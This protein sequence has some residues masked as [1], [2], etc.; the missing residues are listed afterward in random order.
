MKDPV[1]ERSWGIYYL[2]L[3]LT[4]ETKKVPKMDDRGR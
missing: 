1:L 2:D 3:V 4:D